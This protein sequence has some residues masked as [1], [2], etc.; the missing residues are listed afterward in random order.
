M[1][2]RSAEAPEAYKTDGGLLPPLV[3]NNP[4][5]AIAGSLVGAFIIFS[6]TLG[7]YTMWFRARKRALIR[8]ETDVDAMNLLYALGIE[9]HKEV[10]DA[11]MPWTA[12]KM[13]ES[14]SEEK[15]KA[16][17]PEDDDNA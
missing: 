8:A 1:L 5:G 10:V 13:L 12:E 14:S 6:C 9:D 11:A 16:R 3:E 15:V 17:K 4:T 7:C 2:F